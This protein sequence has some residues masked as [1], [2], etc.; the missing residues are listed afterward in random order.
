VHG[1]DAC[2]PRSAAARSR[3]SDRCIASLA[4]VVIAGSQCLWSQEAFSS[5]HV[6]DENTVGVLSVENPARRLDNLSVSP[7]SKFRRLRPTSR[8]VD[9]LIAMMK[10]TLHQ[11][12]RRIRIL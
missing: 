1:N 10:D 12:A 5:H 4:F 8:M 6:E 7:T 9:E 3:R 2:R 11:G